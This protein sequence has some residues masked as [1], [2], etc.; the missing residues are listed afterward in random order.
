MSRDNGLAISTHDSQL[1]VERRKISSSRAVRMDIRYEW[2]ME[3]SYSAR[4]ARLETCDG[5]TG[6]EEKFDFYTQGRN[7]I[8]YDHDVASVTV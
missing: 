2:K 6:E 8:S 7:F 3:K 1:R 5:K 4:A